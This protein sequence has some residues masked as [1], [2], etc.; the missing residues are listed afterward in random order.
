LSGQTTTTESGKIRFRPKARLLYLLG[1]ELITDEV[2]AMV[3]LV[4]NSYDADA[5]RVS[6][7]LVNVTKG[8]EGKIEI[9]D[10]GHGMTLDT[11]KQAWME[12][13]RDNKSDENGA[14][15]RT[16]AFNRL[17]L[18]EKG[19][20]RFSADKLGFKLELVTRF[21]AFEKGGKVSSLS[22]DEVVLKV[23]GTKFTKD[24]YLDE[25]ECEWSVREPV[26]FTGND[27]GA[28]L[29]IS[30]LR[31]PWLEQLVNKVHLGL[32]RLSS[33]MSVSKDFEI[34]FKSNEFTELSERIQ[35]PLLEIAPWFLDAEIDTNG[36]MTYEFRGPKERT[37]SLLDLK[38][39]TDHFRV[40]DSKE[41][42]KPI[43]GPFRMRLYGFERDKRQW[44]RF[45]MDK[46]KVEL[47]EAL[48]GVSI[49]RD[50]FR[51]WPYGER[52]NDWLYLDQRRVQNPGVV[53][54]N[55]R[56]IGYVEISQLTNPY[57]RDKT[58]R[59][60]LIE[61]SNA[62]SDL[63][64]LSACAAHFLGLQ[65]Y[66][67]LPHKKRS[68]VGAEEAKTDITTGTTTL[69]QVSA[70]S[71]EHIAAAK[72]AVDYGDVQT[73][74]TE[75]EKAGVPKDKISESL[76]LISKG[77]ER[78][79]EELALSDEQIQNLMS[80]SGIGLTAERMTHEVVKSATNAKR[81]L[82]K[83][84]E[85]L[86]TGHAEISTLRKNLDSSITQ[87]E[88]VIDV[89]RQME[90]LY[91]SRRKGSESLDVGE[92]ANDMKRFYVNTL[93]DLSIDVE[94]TES[95]KLVVKMSKGHLMQI[96]NNLF[97]NAFY[98]LEQSPPRG[99]G[100]IAIRASG[101]GERSVVFA[102]NGPGVRED[103]KDHLFE[104]FVTTKVNGRGLGLYIIDD[105]L[106][107]Y[108]AEIELT[109]EDK[110]LAGANF[111]ITFLEE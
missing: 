67:A 105:I 108:K 13:A 107:N 43:C 74:K 17:P 97:D 36:T 63:R 93:R 91:Y 70:S 29:R 15:P 68:K 55:D 84:K 54:G 80:L 41:I 57:L 34:T 2:I 62:F 47:L 66:K 60:G 1:H 19:V 101:R 48:S 38:K 44:K 90:P 111:K 72:K 77:T 95:S 7:N 102:D 79:M 10:N 87:L 51:V 69:Q 8:R 110:L 82:Q 58:N 32:S 33:P 6:V 18:G 83:S 37:K 42:R 21:C 4:K 59:E 35:N 50:G 3:E 88:V 23:D 14:R 100:K 39:S 86:D 94:I 28:L 53:L 11:L 65:R 31:S 20:G 71:V 27:H 61:D 46:E 49:Y 103:I 92:I 9:K 73:A 78:L 26:E 45:N 96:F 76:E 81:L 40:A 104:P 12:P 22:D 75:L 30:N 85:L 5:T 56:I 89:M 99:G 64:E 106:A 24:A 52:G 25:I 109:E 16:R 98:W